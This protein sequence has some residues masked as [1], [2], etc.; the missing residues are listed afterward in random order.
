MPWLQAAGVTQPE[1]ADAF[2]R[3]MEA[4]SIFVLPGASD[5]LAAL[6]AKQVGFTGLY[7]SGAAYSASRGLPDLGLVTSEEVAHRAR[8]IV[9]ATDLPL[10]VDIDTGFGGVLNVIRT[11][12]EMV[13]ARV[14]AVQI[15]D[16]VMPKKCGHL[17]GK[18]LVPPEEMAQKVRALKEAAPTLY[19]VARTD[20][21]AVEGIDAA[22]ARARLYVEA[23]ADAIFPEALPDEE[24]FR[25]FRRGV[26][27]PL[28]ANMTEFGRT[29][30]IPAS[31]FEQ[32]GYEAVIFPVT[33]LRMA[34]RA[35]E[36]AYREL[37]VSGTQRDLL[38]QM[39]TRQELYETIDYFGCEALDAKIAASTLPSDR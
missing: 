31:Q 36:R 29:P 21:V 6:I 39:Q 28:V 22:M 3:G 20:A 13:E 30:I 8:D 34:A 33:A 7:L 37:F 10:L 4:R 35:Y 17:S 14:A 26:E 27:A 1:L 38:D 15:E 11:G 32:W 2:R 19:V 12:K 16:Q 5:A 23:G 25:T 18:A 9:R 24:A